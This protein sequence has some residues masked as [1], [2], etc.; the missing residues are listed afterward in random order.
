MRMY[1]F[2][3]HCVQYYCYTV[4]FKKDQFRVVSY[5]FVELTSSTA[6]LLADSIIYR[7]PFVPFL[8]CNDNALQ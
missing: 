1:I 8:L 5:K 3:Q 6:L 7:L 4:V 2:N